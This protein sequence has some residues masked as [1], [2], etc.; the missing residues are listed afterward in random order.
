MVRIREAK[1]KTY[2]TTRIKGR[3][4]SKVSTMIMIICTAVLTLAILLAART[5]PCCA[6]TS[7]KPLMMNSRATITMTTQSE[8]R[9]KYTRQIRAEQ[10]RSLSAR[11]SIN[12]PKF[13]TILY[14]RAIRPSKK[15]VMQ[16][17]IKTPT[18]A[19]RAQGS[20]S[21]SIRN[22]IKT[23]IRQ[24]RRIV[25]LLGR[26]IRQVLLSDHNRLMR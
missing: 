17:A 26:F 23:G 15:S 1:I 2:S 14:F 11:G 12:L 22:T 25:S 16:A 18:A 9:W 8:I 6:A 24:T 21:S 10:T 7:R 4:I 5:R 19:Y 3:S 20:I 13:V